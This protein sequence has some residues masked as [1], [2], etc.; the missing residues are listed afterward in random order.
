LWRL[1]FYDTLGD[2]S[3]RFLFPRES[4]FSVLFKNIADDIV[5]VSVLFKEFSH[6]FSEAETF[7]KRAA[8]I[9]CK[10]DTS[11][12]DAIKLM[13]RSFITPFDREDIHFLVHELD[14]I[15]DILE[16]HIRN[17]YLYHFKS[18]PDA[19]GK[20]ADLILD[21]SYDIQKLVGKYLDP[22]TYTQE[23]ASLKQHLYNLE[24]EADA[25]FANAIRT[26]FEKTKDPIELIKEKDIL[27]GL[28]T[29]MDKFLSVGNTIENII[30]KSR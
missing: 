6:K 9:E 12:K 28:E 1:F 4:G 7:K 14:D 8:A 22:P 26:L 10:A 21:A 19:M 13:N 24:A 29:V 2:M 5:E 11:V 18:T 16:D 15:I 25:V 20:F 17:I 3:P 27:E 30:V 23:V